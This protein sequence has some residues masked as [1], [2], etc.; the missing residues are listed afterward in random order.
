MGRS[1]SPNCI[2]QARA[3]SGFPW[4]ELLDVVALD[5]VELDLQ[6]ARLRPF[7]IST[8]PNVARHG[9]ELIDAHIVDQLLILNAFGPYTDHTLEEVDMLCGAPHK[10]LCGSNDMQSRGRKLL[11]AA[12]FLAGF[13]RH[14]SA[15]TRSCSYAR[16][17]Q[18]RVPAC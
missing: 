13:T 14:K 7:T 12:G 11:T 3:Q 15:C 5:V 9:L 1:R 6:H 17:G 18:L 8:E 2:R 10:M 16:T 4:C